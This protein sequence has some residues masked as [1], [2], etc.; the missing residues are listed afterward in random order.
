MFLVMGAF[1]LVG[2]GNATKAPSTTKAPAQTTTKAGGATTTAAPQ[3]YTGDPLKD[4]FE[5]E[6]YTSVYDEIG[7]QVTI[8]MV[9]EDEDGFAHVSVDG[10][11]YTLGMDFLSMAMVYNCEP[12]GAF[13]TAEKVYNEWYRYFLQRWNYLVPEIPLYSNQYF[14]VYNSKIENF[15]TSPY[16][17]PADA[18]IGA[19]VRA[20]ET[21][22]VILGSSTQLGGAFRSASWG[23]SSPAASDNDVMSLTSGY[24]TIMTDFNGVYHFNMYDAETGYGVLKSEPTSVINEDSSVT[25]TMEIVPGLKFSDGT[26]IKAKNYIA[27]LLMDSTAVGVAAGSKGQAGQQVVGFKAFNAYDGTGDPVYFS[28]VKLYA[29][30]EYKWS[31]TYTADFAGYY[32]AYLQAGFSPS[33]L[34]LWLGNTNPES[35][36]IMDENGNAGLATAFYAKDTKGEYLVAKDVK[37]NLKW[38]S[39]LPYSG[40][41]K[42]SNYD[43]SSLTATLVL[44]D[45]YPGDAYRGKATIA[46]I[47]YIK[48]EEETQTSKLQAHELDVLAGVTGGDE[49]EAVLALVRDAANNLSETHY[50][51][52]GYGKLGFRCDFGPSQF[53]EVRQAI[54]YTINRPEFAQT[55][56]GGYG[57]VVNG[58]YYEELPAYKANKEAHKIDLNAYTYSTSS[59]NEVLEEAGWVYNAD[60]TAYS[61]TGIRYKKLEGAEMTYDNLTFKSTDNKYKTEFAN[62]YYYMPLAIN[63]FG[64]QPNSVTDQL[65]TSWK[66]SKAATEDIGMYITYT[67]SDFYTALYG[68]LMR[69]EEYGYTGTPRLNA[70]NFATSFSS[71][72]YDVSYYWTINPDYYDVYSDAFLMDE[73]DFFANYNAE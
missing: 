9:T 5:R 3:G 66:T 27:G 23:K 36:I 8:D 33:P 53:T 7:S 45:Q 26:E 49:T 32:Y 42:V 63:W 14:D 30:N 48:T 16:W 71:T 41:Y 57:T 21:N 1:L 29:D 64:T 25:F 17:G 2:C 24:S 55:F 43:E 13:D 31:V 56:T 19:T 60:G 68:E 39:A 52:A 47:S 22:S 20:G 59:A 18:I 69:I 73:A 72:V 11:D 70:V 10:V 4:A 38:N 65:V 61:G 34:A 28:G 37:E 15:H 50:D 6:D 35:M 44:N 46:T 54:M 12:K 58:P 67:T 40:P 62:G 51:R